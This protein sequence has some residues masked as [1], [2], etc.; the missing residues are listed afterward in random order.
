[1]DVSSIR[2]GTRMTSQTKDRIMVLLQEVGQERRSVGAFLNPSN[3][4]AIYFHYAYHVLEDIGGDFEKKQCMDSMYAVASQYRAAKWSGGPPPGCPRTAF[5]GLPMY[6]GTSAVPNPP[7]TIFPH[8]LIPKQ[9]LL[10]PPSFLCVGSP[11]QTVCFTLH[12]MRM[13]IM[14]NFLQTL[15]KNMLRDTRERNNKDNF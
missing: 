13:W 8:L 14:A 3:P 11:K 1:M 12:R 4:C 6:P 9:N 5:Q 2:G 10:L 15:K 7:H